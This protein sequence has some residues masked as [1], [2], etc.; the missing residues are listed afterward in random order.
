MKLDSISRDEFR[1]V[2]L[3]ETASLR[4]SRLIPVILSGGAAHEAMLRFL[5]T[6]APAFDELWRRQAFTGKGATP[7]VFENEDAVLAYVRSTR[8]AIGYVSLGN[9]ARVR[10]VKWK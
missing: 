3:G 10:L 1:S 9:D 4:G 7:R 5:G 6:S 8:D 2:F